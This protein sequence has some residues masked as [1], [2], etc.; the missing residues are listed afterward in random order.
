MRRVAEEGVPTMMVPRE[1]VREELLA[2]AEARKTVTYGRLMKKDLARNNEIRRQPPPMIATPV[3]EQ[4]SADPLLVAPAAREQEF[5][6]VAPR[7][8]GSAVN[9]TGDSSGITI[10]R[11]SEAPKRPLLAGGIFKQPAQ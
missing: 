11:S 5:L 8:T 10:V 2:A 3:M 1:D 4:T 6:S 7:G 9:I